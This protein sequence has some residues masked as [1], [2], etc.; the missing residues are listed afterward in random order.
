[1]RNALLFT[2]ILLCTQIQAQSWSYVGASCPNTEGSAK[3][4]FKS[5]GNIISAS[6]SFNQLYVK[7]WNGTTWVALPAP[8][9]TGVIGTMQLEMHQDT[10][11]LGVSNNGFK[12]FKWNGSGWTQLGATISATF[13]D[14]NHDFVLDNNGVPYVCHSV[15]RN[16]YRF[17]GSAWTIVHTLPQ[18]S[19]PVTYGYTFGVDNAITFNSNNELIYCAVALNRQ[20][21]K[22]LTSNFQEVLVGDT[23]IRLPSFSQYGATLKRNANGDLFALFGKFGGRSFVKKLVG[24]NWELF[25]DSSTFDLPSGFHLLEF[26]GPNTLVMAV[27]GN[28]DKKVWVCAGPTAPFQLLDLISHTGFTQIT[29]LDISPADG[30]VHVAF[31]CLPT[32]SVMR[33]DLGLTSNKELEV[34]PSII[35]FPNPANDVLQIGNVS[36]PPTW[37]EMYTTDGRFIA[38]GAPENS[39]IYLNNLKPG[40]YRL[41]IIASNGRRNHILFQK[42]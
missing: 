15:N 23:V 2:L 25:G 1:M 38:S 29:D 42:N 32:H 13:S 33:Y 9:T 11:Y 12:C 16:I 14:G 21:V 18:G 20:F 17:N 40:L 28:V 27:S 26:A 31:N 3:I 7:E 10:A 37:F 34:N 39:K 19:F 4:K 8:A 6:Y 30:K 36:H 41:N 24:N 35:V 22:K 5:N